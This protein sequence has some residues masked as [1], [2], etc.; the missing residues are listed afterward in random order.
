MRM[1]DGGGGDAD[2]E[3]EVDVKTAAYAVNRP[4]TRRFTKGK[5]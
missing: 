3:L 2:A 4:E 5:K 1:L